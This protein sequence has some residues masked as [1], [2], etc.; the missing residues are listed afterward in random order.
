MW[1]IGLVKCKSCGGTSHFSEDG[2]TETDYWD[3]EQ[4]SGRCECFV[5][6][7]D[8]GGND[9][10]EYL[11]DIPDGVVIIYRDAFEFECII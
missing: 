4:L 11:R 2:I 5:G 8:M 9:N 3:D 1:P 6:F 7:A 10:E